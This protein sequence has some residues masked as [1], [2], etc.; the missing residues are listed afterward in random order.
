MPENIATFISTHQWVIALAAVWIIPWKGVALWRAA[1]NRSVAWFVIL[2]LVNTVGILDII[3]IFAF[4]N[5]AIPQPVET[6]KEQKNERMVLDI[7]S[8]KN[9]LDGL[10]QKS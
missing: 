9:N 5:K 10:N 8:D 2:L 3:Y 4:S 1:R 6:Q 7:K